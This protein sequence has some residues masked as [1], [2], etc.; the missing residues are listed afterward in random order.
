MKGIYASQH[1][2]AE[3]KRTNRPKDWPFATA[4][5]VNLLDAG[6]ARGWLHIYNDELLLEL[7]ERIPCPPEIAARRPVLGLA[8]RRD[9]RLK[10]AVHV[11]IQYWH[12]LD[13]A[14]LR[15]H[16]RVLRPY[17]VAV[18]KAKIKHASLVEQHQARLACAERWLPTNP[19][20]DHG[21]TA[22]VDEARAELAKMIP[23]V[24][25][26]FLPDVTDNFRTVMQ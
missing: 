1:T 10:Q 9:D 22:L 21:L 20:R 14:R 8:L 23:T 15:V 25:L 24:P 26:E 12:E 17:L 16:E 4:L 2:L 13:L 3:M 19:L 11:E 7:A 18:R 5:G 6:D